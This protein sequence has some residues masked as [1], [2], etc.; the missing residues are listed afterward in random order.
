M[1]ADALAMHDGVLAVLDQTR[2]GDSDADD[3]VPVHP[4]LGD[5]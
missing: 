2:D 3:G 1:P 5:H 4:R